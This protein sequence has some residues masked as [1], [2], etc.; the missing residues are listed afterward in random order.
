M[1]APKH[2]FIKHIYKLS[3]M[4]VGGVQVIFNEETRTL[5]F[6]KS[7][8]DE[9]KKI[10]LIKSQLGVKG[11]AYSE[12]IKSEAFMTWLKDFF[13]EGLNGKDATNLKEFEVQILGIEDEV[14]IYNGSSPIKIKARAKHFMAGEWT[15]D[16]IIL[17]IPKMT[18]EGLLKL[19]RG[20]DREYTIVPT[21]VKKDCLY[22]KVSPSGET[23]LMLTYDSNKIINFDIETRETKIT[24]GKKMDLIDLLNILSYDNPHNRELLKDSVTL[25]YTIKKNYN[26]DDELESAYLTKLIGLEEHRTF[27]D[28]L[29]EKNINVSSFRKQLDLS[30]SPSRY[31][32]Y[33]LAK[34]IKDNDGNVL[35][36]KGSMI[37]KDVVSRMKEKEIEV[38]YVKNITAREG[39][40]YETIMIKALRKGTVIP[41]ELYEC[42]YGTGLEV[43]QLIEKDT[44]LP[45]PI[46]ISSDTELSPALIKF[47]HENDP[48]RKSIYYKLV[49]DSMRKSEL[50]I[51]RP[52]F[53][54][55]KANNSGRIEF[56]DLLAIASLLSDYRSGLS[57]KYETYNIDTTFR[58]RLKLPHEILK[59]LIKEAK[60][61]KI[62]SVRSKERNSLAKE[63][64]IAFR[65]PDVLMNLLTDTDEV[66]KLMSIKSQVV[67]MVDTSNLAAYISSLTKVNYDVK[68]TD[69]VPDSLRLIALS[70]MGKLCPFETPAS[71]RIGLT[72]NLT[73]LVQIDYKTGDFLLPCF[74][75]KH[76]E[77][78]ATLD[79]KITYL[80]IDDEEN[81]SVTVIDMLTLNDKKEIT[82]KGLI[83][84]KTFDSYNVNKFVLKEVSKEKVTAVIVDPICMVSLTSSLLPFMGMN[85]A[86]RASFA[87]AMMKQTKTLVKPE[88]PHVFT[89]TYK[90]LGKVCSRFN[91]I[92]KTDGFIQA[93]HPN[94]L[95]TKDANGSIIPYDIR[96]T[97]ISDYTLSFMKDVKQEKEEFKKGDILLESSMF[98]N[99][100]YTVGVNALVGY[101]PWGDNYEDA[102]INSVPLQAKL[103][104]YSVGTTTVEEDE[105]LT[106]MPVKCNPVKYYDT[107]GDK[108]AE[109]AV[110]VKKKINAFGDHQTS[111]KVIKIKESGYVIRS[112]HKAYKPNILILKSLSISKLAG[113][114]KAVNRHGNKGVSSVTKKASEMPML[115]NGVALEVVYNPIGVGARM[116]IGQVA[117]CHLG[118][119]S[120]VLNI[121]CLVNHY[122]GASVEEIELLMNFVYDLANGEV[123]VTLAKY[124]GQLPDNL[125][126]YASNEI[127]NIKYWED[128]FDRNGE[129]E[130]TIPSA[131]GNKYIKNK[132]LVGTNYI[133]KLHQESGKKLVTRGT[134]LTEKRNNLTY[135]GEKSMH[136]TQGQKFGYMELNALC[137]HGASHLI[138]ECM[139]GRG[140]NP[141]EVY[142]L[143]SR[144]LGLP[145]IE[146]ESI[147]RSTTR[148]KHYM[149]SMGINIDIEDDN[150][151]KV[152]L[153]TRESI[154]KQPALKV[155]SEHL[156]VT[157][158]A[159]EIDLAEEL[160]KLGW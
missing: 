137:S 86:T 12:Y 77:G 20:D 11:K 118:L 54:N 135:I 78:R 48:D 80:S 132:V 8:L 13:E 28:R 152:N 32:G 84:V 133:L 36:S 143:A 112:G 93:K 109:I 10:E 61:F 104:S 66:A 72:N 75:V 5:D 27:E 43:G 14:T 73:G 82:N 56:C 136:T 24:L 120:T 7:L 158:K 21:I 64:G 111:E 42:L 53:T 22:S 140:D 103:Q 95:I 33:E 68:N 141:L 117:E 49:E 45:L 130:V 142:N 38:F 25:E 50:I 41:I 151:K 154:L 17:S 153:D 90:L 96:D 51:I 9:D 19:N 106:F 115:K 85:D 63:A 15:S 26:N 71:K 34:D 129:A 40:L 16:F 160:A 123:N 126:K 97:S 149:N 35:A 131:D 147:R 89:E 128:T 159:S 92:A 125:L 150:G 107:S 122:G 67:V 105:K 87:S 81:H 31:L 157:N 124:K 30:L 155:D 52:V 44:I 55:F 23:S 29:D 69:S 6:N 37:T 65:N 119:I 146:G 121:N 18:E 46:I 134:V 59:D 102:L 76:S 60:E 94:R 144:E 145:E 70:S 156:A 91:V 114:D 57:L 88:I 98:T 108:G 47:I 113:G 101:M 148:F 39:L 83:T 3:I 100:I 138:D 139:N 62:S 79:D 116:N 99:G 74:L 110:N 1:L 58:N 2:H 127:D 4:N